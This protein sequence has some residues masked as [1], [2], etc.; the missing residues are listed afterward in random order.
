MELNGSC[1]KRKEYQSQAIPGHEESV[2]GAD[3]RGKCEQKWKEWNISMS[4]HEKS[5]SYK[6]IVNTCLSFLNEGKKWSGIQ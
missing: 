5:N 2:S 1:H 3:E 4:R 6:T